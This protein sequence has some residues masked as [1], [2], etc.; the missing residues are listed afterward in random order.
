MQFDR[1]I[2][3]LFSIIFKMRVILNGKC[4]VDPLKAG[5]YMITLIL[6]N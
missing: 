4:K 2:K 3:V 1:K 6:F 5:I